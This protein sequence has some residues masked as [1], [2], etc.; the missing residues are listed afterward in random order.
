[1]ADVQVR[2]LGTETAP[3]DAVIP[4][5]SEWIMKACYASYDGSSAAG[6]F[7]PLLR[8]KSDA[9]L[10]VFESKISDTIA[11]G[12]SADTSWFPHVGDV[13]PIEWG[14]YLAY[15]KAAPLTVG[16][17]IGTDYVEPDF[18]GLL[19][20]GSNVLVPSSLSQPFQVATPGFYGFT[21][22]YL[23][24]GGTVGTNPYTHSVIYPPGHAN[25]ASWSF[26]LEQPPAP[27]PDANVSSGSATLL[28]YL[29]TSDI[30][31]WWIGNDDTVDQSFYYINMTVARF[32]S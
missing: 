29:S 19:H 10:V 28:T 23:W 6:S 20:E 16:H 7:Q 11:A 5:S 14:V 25:R 1:M 2:P 21:C 15:P 24:S 13:A 22:D 12:A 30:V 3:A 9:G 8:V 4:Q 31:S 32:G 17:T 18:T 26:K 27:R